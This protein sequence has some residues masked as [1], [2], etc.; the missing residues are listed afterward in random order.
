M[1]DELRGAALLR[2]ARGR[3][4]A[5]L[6][7]LARIICAI[8]DAALSLG[9]SLRA[10]EV[11][12]LWVSGHQIEA[13]DVLVETGPLASAAAGPG[14]PG[15]GSPAPLGTQPGPDRTVTQK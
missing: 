4:A 6:D 2:G 3:P 11:N 9:S 8:G 15:P 12:P 14:A 10:L 7:A 5:D 13:L 1:L